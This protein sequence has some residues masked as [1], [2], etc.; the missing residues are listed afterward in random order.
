MGLLDVVPEVFV[1]PVV[2][3]LRFIHALAQA[4]RAENGALKG[5]GKQP[6]AAAGA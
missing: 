5:A 1:Q 6:A 3:K 4:G 2:E